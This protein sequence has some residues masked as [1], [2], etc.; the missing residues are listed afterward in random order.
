VVKTA[1]NSAIF[2]HYFNRSRMVDIFNNKNMLH[3]LL[4]SLIHLSCMK[5]NPLFSRTLAISY[6]YYIYTQEA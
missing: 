4:S 3:V 6:F 5:T 2:N 1:Y